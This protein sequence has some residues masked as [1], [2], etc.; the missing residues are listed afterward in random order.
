MKLVEVLPAAPAEAEEAAAWYAER[1]PRV[2]ARFADE[3]EIE[4]ALTRIA[5]A[6]DRWPSTRYGTRRVRLTRFPYL[7]VYRDEPTRILVMA[8]AHAKQRPGYRSK[9]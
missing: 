2:A 7:V 9:R 6:P 8:I 5:E 3:D 4:A 1:D